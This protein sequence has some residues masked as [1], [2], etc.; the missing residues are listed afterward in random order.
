M[1]G[2][3][4]WPT[5]IDPSS[6]IQAATAPDEVVI[7]RSA[8]QNLVASVFALAGVFL[9]SYLLIT[10][11]KL[12]PCLNIIFLALFLIFAFFSIRSLLDRTV[13][14]KITRQEISFA[15]GTSYKWEIVRNM[16]IE[17]KYT[18]IGGGS[19]IEKFYLTLEPVF[20][21]AVSHQRV[22]R[23]HRISGWIIPLRK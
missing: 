6:P 21:G 8:F 7:R 2:R 3:N 23:S 11:Q 20:A 10:N 5:N 9:F 14:V 19:G 22:F 18:N 13:K 17:R 1:P 15:D 12:F 16:F 4:T